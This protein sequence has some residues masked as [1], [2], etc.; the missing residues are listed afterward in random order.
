M[1]T[2]A[3]LNSR[4][5]SPNSRRFHLKTCFWLEMIKTFQLGYGLYNLISAR[6]WFICY[7]FE[8]K[9]FQLPKA[10]TENMR[11]RTLICFDDF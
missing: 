4:I 11:N 2:V 10:N 3:E 6:L 9:L 5:L 7:P 1:Q 8:I